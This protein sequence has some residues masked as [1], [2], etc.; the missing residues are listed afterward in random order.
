MTEIRIWE[1]SEQETVWRTQ[2]HSGIVKGVCATRHQSQFLSCSTDKTVKVWDS[3]GS[4]EAI[5]T[6][7]GKYAFTGISHHRSSDIFATSGNSVEL[8]D[9]NR[10]EPMQEF[11]WGADSYQSV[12]FNQVETNIFASCGT[13]RT[14][15]LYDMRTSKPLSKLVMAVSIWCSLSK[16]PK[17]MFYWYQM[18]TNSI[19]WNPIE[20]FTFVAVSRGAL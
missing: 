2:A 16:R 20:A 19:A 8:W 3:N 9:V 18:R 1:L 4:A 14:I 17:L 10:S 15:V 6:F 13:D 5:Q 7:L 12:K 11:E